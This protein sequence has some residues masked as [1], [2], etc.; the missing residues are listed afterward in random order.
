MSVDIDLATHAR[1][2]E[3]FTRPS[4]FGTMPS[5]IAADG[6]R[7]RFEGGHGALDGI[8]GLW[9]VNLGYGNRAISHA[10]SRALMDASYLGLFRRTHRYAVEAAEALLRA[11]AP[12]DFR[13]V[14]Y[15]TSGGSA[16]DAAS[17]ICRQF[18][19]LNG[20]PDR[21]LIVS[22]RGS[23]HGTTF[24]AF[25]LTGEDLGQSTYGVDRS[26][27]RLVNPNAPTE[28]ERLLSFCGDEVA[29]IVV[30]PVLGS[31]CFELSDDMVRAILQARRDHGVLVVADEVATGFGRTG[32]M[33]ASHR[34]PSQPDLM[35]TSKGLT[36]GTCAASAVLMGP[37]VT[38]A[39][40][41]HD[42]ALGQGETQAGT[43]A[44]CSA[45]MATISEF[46]RLDAVAAGRQVAER[47]DAG[48]LELAEAI[49]GS[50][51]TGRGCFR[52]IHFGMYGG[53]PVSG[54]VISQLVAECLRAGAIVQ[55]GPSSLQLVPALT[56]SAS[57]LDRLLGVVG[58][59]VTR[60]LSR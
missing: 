19:D 52:A 33:F 42:A 39:F 4:A 35:T 31:G 23:Y 53:T 13:R 18:H 49:P 60:C 50:G 41:E 2:V 29:A 59:V 1:V 10:I 24:G 45:I 43:P 46:E 3:S 40:D 11:A 36:N 5:A 54:E 17:K 22:L 7:V 20:D 44:A 30:E 56:Y 25:A 38:E 37:R 32:T 57:D 51:L 27:V 6:V 26:L 16:L 28:L 48:M 12:H 55:P 34:W 58:E 9:N 15:T 8:S 14:L 47:L 21:K